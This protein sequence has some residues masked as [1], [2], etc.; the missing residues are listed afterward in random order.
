MVVENRG[1]GGGAGG[2]GGWEVSLGGQAN[3]EGKD[4]DLGGHVDKRHG[5][6]CLLPPG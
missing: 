3:M 6:R 4:R 2:T 1:R 5:N